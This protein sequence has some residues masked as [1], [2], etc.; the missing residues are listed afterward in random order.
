MAHGAGTGQVVYRD[1]DLEKRQGRKRDKEKKS[2]VGS[3]KKEEKE[4]GGKEE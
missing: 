3:R 2:R 1:R 4:K